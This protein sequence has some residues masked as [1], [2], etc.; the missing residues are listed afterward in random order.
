MY[1][2]IANKHKK[3]I[4]YII[5]REV[6]LEQSVG[7]AEPYIWYWYDV[8]DTTYHISGYGDNAKEAKQ[9]F[10]ECKERLEKFFEK[11][12]LS[13]HIEGVDFVFL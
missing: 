9:K 8:P 13:N 7:I 3:H 6:K 1:I 4:Y 11:K 10:L 2:C 12:G 5:M